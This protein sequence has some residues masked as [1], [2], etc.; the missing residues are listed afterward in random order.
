[1]RKSKRQGKGC[2]YHPMRKVVSRDFNLLADCY[3]EILSCGHNNRA[4][5]YG[6][7]RKCWQCN[8]PRPSGPKVLGGTR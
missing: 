6:T 2:M 7:K 5:F 8:E 3:D 4:S 1:M